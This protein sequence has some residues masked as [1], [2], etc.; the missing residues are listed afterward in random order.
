[1]SLLKIITYYNEWTK[2][3]HAEV[4]ERPHVSATG[5]TRNEASS[6]AD[7]ALDEGEKDG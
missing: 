2:E 5:A 7:A 4:P 6:K 1:M 3:F